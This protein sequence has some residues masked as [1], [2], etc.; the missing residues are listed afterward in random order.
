MGMVLE[1][2]SLIVG[3]TDTATHCFYK[4]DGS[5]F[6]GEIYDND[7]VFEESD[8]YN[9]KNKVIN[10][11]SVSVDF[12]PKYVGTYTITA[13]LYSKSVSKSFNVD[14][15]GISAPEIT[16]YYG[17]PQTLEISIEGN[18]DVVADQIVKVSFNSKNYEAK[19]D[20]D[21]IARV[22]IDNIPSELGKYNITVNVYDKYVTSAVT[23]LSTIGGSDVAKFYGD[24]SQFE[25]RFTDK[26][27]QYLNMGKLIGYQIDNLRTKYSPILNNEGIFDIDISSLGVGEHNITVFNLLTKENTTFTITILPGF[28]NENNHNNI[29]Q[30]NSP[31]KD[32]SGNV[33]SFDSNSLTGDLFYDYS[34]ASDNLN[35]TDEVAGDK[36]N[37]TNHST[38]SPVSKAI[39]NTQSNG[40]NNNLWWIILAILAVIAAGAIIK[41]YKE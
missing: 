36:G 39:D 3:Q 34:L 29:P 40:G 30:S 37:V 22:L 31:S 41:K 15:Y 16:T 20:G 26:N 14:F 19:T 28:G 8:Y 4:S 25:V 24:G 38:N 6:T 12:V 7:V 2:T 13:N 18:K 11:N 21:G 33:N 23:V 9:L 1:K 5:L 32:Y 10:S 17:G 27:G 35:A